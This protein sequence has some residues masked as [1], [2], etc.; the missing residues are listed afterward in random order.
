MLHFDGRQGLSE[1][2]QDGACDGME[3]KIVARRSAE[4]LEVIGNDCGPVM[5][6]HYIWQSY[7][8]DKEKTTIWDA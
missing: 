7:G 3:S 5:L 6:E 8:T 1:Y 4:W 2:G